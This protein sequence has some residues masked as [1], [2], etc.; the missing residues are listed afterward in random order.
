M[1]STDAGNSPQF[2]K[3]EFDSNA[4]KHLYRGL[5]AAAQAVGCT[6]GPRGKTVLIQRR[7]AL[8]VTTKDG[9][10]VAKAIN[11]EDPVER[12]GAELVKE[13]ASQ[14]NDE[15]G[16][17][18]TT[19]TVLTSVMVLEGMK[20][21]E[22]G[23]ASTKLVSGMHKAVEIIT[24]SLKQHATP[25]DTVDQI[26][27]VGTISANGDVKIGKIIADAMDRVGRDGIITVEDA[28]G[29]ST[30][31]D[32]VE[33][34]QFD[35]GYLSPFFVTNNDK[36]NAT[37]SDTYVL[38]TDR[39][40]NTLKELVPVLEYVVRTQRSLLIIADGVEGEA[41][42][43]LVLNRLK[44]NLQVVAVKAPGY[45]PSRVE[46]LNDICAMTGAKLVSASTGI[47]LEAVTHNELGTCK[48]IVVDAKSTTIVG[49]GKHTQAVQDRLSDLR[50]QLENVTLDVED[51]SA[52]RV[53]IAKLSG[54]VAIIK[55]GGATEIEMVERKYRIEDALHATRA[56]TEEGIVPGGGSALIHAC[57]V[58]DF[59]DVWDKEEIAGVEAVRRACFA[60]LRLIVQNAGGSPDVIVNELAKDCGEARRGYDAMKNEFVDMYISGVI[61]PVKVT[62]VALQNAASIATTFLTLDAVIFDSSGD[63]N[64]DDQ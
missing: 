25:V 40:L 24:Q 54:G 22:A 21:L 20:L 28:K 6:L 45:G 38:V 29:T 2:T 23:Y 51:V 27:Q 26:V 50:S 61:D 35:R 33:G 18:T 3:I 34:M 53:R 31:M 52:L 59:R 17:G 19:A 47:S 49:D 4:R 30:T 44:T 11:L 39:T 37:Y 57:R 60:P 46:L 9:V 43:A 36:M 58:A 32:A 48:K 41:L 42:Q 1:Q 15:A 62:R 14:T 63:K 55:V 56:A 13:A 64:A 8:P 16:D 12:M 10:T 7:G 5:S